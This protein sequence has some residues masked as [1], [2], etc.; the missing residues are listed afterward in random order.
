MTIIIDN[1][2]HNLLA[3]PNQ[4]NILKAK[5]S[6]N[7]IT[8]ISI[9][10]SNVDILIN[11]RDELKKTIIDEDPDVILLNEIYPKYEHNISAQ[12]E[13]KLEGYNANFNT[14]FS[15]GIAIYVKDTI[16]ITHCELKEIKSVNENLWTLINVNNTKILIGCIYRS[17]SNDNATSVN[18][19]TEMFNTVT[20]SNIK[21]D[22]LLITGDFNL[23]EIKWI[24]ILVN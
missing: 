17:D 11:K 13:F 3:L 20:N 24:N 19:L 5:T 14:H 18:Q 15:R 4:L 8:I 1:Y 9:I 2:P 21:Y 10:Y 12:L 23:M 6:L 7:L 22:K 16:D